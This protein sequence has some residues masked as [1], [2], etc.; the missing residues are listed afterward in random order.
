MSNLRKE[1]ESILF[2]IGKE[3]TLHRVDK[4]NFILEIDYDKYIDNILAAIKFYEES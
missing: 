4:D 2:E 3:S 1:L